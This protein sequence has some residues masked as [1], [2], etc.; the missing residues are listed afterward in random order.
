VVLKDAEELV[1]ADVDRGRL[2]HRLVERLYA[3]TLVVNLGS[4]I[5]VTE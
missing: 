3:H 5:A 2:N 4:N 1:E